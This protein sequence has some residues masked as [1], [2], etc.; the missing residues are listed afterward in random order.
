[1]EEGSRTI[2]IADAIRL[3]HKLNKQ[4]TY[5][6]YDAQQLCAL[7]RMSAEDWRAVHTAYQKA[8]WLRPR[9]GLVLGILGLG[10]L[11][12]MA[13]RGLTWPLVICAIVLYNVAGSR[14]GKRGGHRTGYVDGYTDGF[15]EG[16]D[17]ALQI[18]EEDR[19]DAEE[20]ST[21]MELDEM[22]VA[23]LDKQVQSDPMPKTQLNTEDLA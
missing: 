3:K 10:L 20:R 7:R 8:T 6:G 2:S 19:K 23:H 15:D 13:L 9:S 4:V 16:I 22:T 11:L 14:Y 17:K 21:E 1:M 18:S 12:W 5:G